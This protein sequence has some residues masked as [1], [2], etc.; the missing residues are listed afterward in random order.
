MEFRTVDASSRERV[1]A[2]LRGHWFSTE[3]VTHGT[4][5][6][7][8]K[9]EGV[10]AFEGGE[11]RGLVTYLVRGP[12]CEITSLDSLD[13]NRGVGTELVAR[14]AAA[15]RAAGCR[16]LIV[17]TT[18][19]NLRAIGFY[20][21]RG[22]DMA[23]FRRNALD[24]SRRLKPEIPLLGEHGIPLRHEIEFEMPLDPSSAAG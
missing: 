12:V 8:A 23:R 13:E 19:D 9:A 24:V 1:N 18:N 10:A 5:Y 14:A 22:F 7:L 21:K 17:V 2:F 15:A 16:R 11:I 4:V 3:M 20:Q 6:D